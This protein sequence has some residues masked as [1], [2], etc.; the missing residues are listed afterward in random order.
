MTSTT[1]V[2]LLFPYNQTQVMSSWQECHRNE[3]VYSQGISLAST[4]HSV[5]SLIGAL[6]LTLLGW[7]L[8]G[9]PS[10][11]PSSLCNKLLF[12]VQG[13]CACV[14]S[15]F[16]CVRLLATLWTV[17]CH[18]PLSMGFSRQEYWS[19]LSCP[20]PGYLPDPDI[21]PMSLT[22]PTLAGRFFTISTTCRA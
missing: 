13:V 2:H 1:W 14:V 11:H 6:T 22:S 12:C 20:L 17:A 4:C 3:A 15:C 21:E 8:P 19:G 5:Y 16:S 10:I 7:C 18:T 9:L